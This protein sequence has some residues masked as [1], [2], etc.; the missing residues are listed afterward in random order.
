MREGIH[1]P[2]DR[3]NPHPTLALSTKVEEDFVAPLTAVRGALEILRDVHDLTEDEHHRFVETA[4][5]SCACLETAVAELSA[6]VYAAGK[7]S[8]ENASAADLSSEPNEYTQRIEILSEL[9]VIEVDFS[10]FEFS[11]SQLVN[12]FYDEI[13]RQITL[14]DREWY[15]VT[16]YR[17]CS[18]W[19]EAWVAFAHRAKKI[20][21]NNS[22]GSVRYVDATS[23]GGKTPAGTTGN[24]PDQYGSRETALAQIEKLKTAGS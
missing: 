19:P 13:E 18:I 11:N 4:L 23:A 22:L 8:S 20:Q 16:N 1:L 12:D 10:D 6:S 17:N 14:T 9:D 5:R 7:Q 15:F 2:N 21:V 24:H 3:P